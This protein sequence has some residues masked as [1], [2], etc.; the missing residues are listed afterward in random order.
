[1]FQNAFISSLTEPQGEI[2]W[3]LKMLI[4]TAQYTTFRYI[5]KKKILSQPPFGGKK[6][7]GWS[8]RREGVYVFRFHQKSTRCG[9][10][11]KSS[12]F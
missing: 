4:L 8:S 12:I 3:L 6:P 2:K 9:K 11:Y 10:E 7:K 5:Q 1:M